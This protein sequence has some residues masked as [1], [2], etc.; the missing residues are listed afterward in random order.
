MAI[1]NNPGTGWAILP[2]AGKDH[3]ATFAVK[4][5]LG[6]AGGSTLSF[7]LDQNHG[8]GHAIGRFR[9]AVATDALPAPAGGDVPAPIQALL[10]IAVAE[11]TAE[12]RQALAAHYRSIAPALE[13][14]RQKLAATKKSRDDQNNQIPTSLITVAVAPRP[15]RVLPRG[16][17]MDDSGEEVLPGVPATLPQ[18]PAKEGRLT[19]LDLAQ[20]LMAR[21]NPL[22]SRVLANRLWKLYF[23]AGL[24]GKLDDLGV[25]GSMAHASRASRLAVCR[26]VGGRLGRETHDQ[27]DRDVQDVSA[28]VVGQRRRQRQGPVQ[29]LAGPAI[30]VSPGCRDRPRRGAMD[31][32]SAGRADRRPERQTV[33]AA[34]LLGS[35]STFPN[36]NGRTA[37]ATT[38][39]AVGCIR[40]GSGN[41]C[42]PACWPSM[43]PAARNARPIGRA[44]IRRCSRW[45]CSTT[46]PTSKRPA[47]WPS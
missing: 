38:C 34:A 2:A 30:A 4:E 5:P 9:L 18:P 17:W 11:R 23:G 41:I 13:P 27:N 10:A 42:I 3:V 1:D 32:R 43:R 40:T 39:I 7:T 31:Q 21:D 45:C 35:I 20:W 33:P 47:C 15:I 29:S 8:T 25:A 12:Q 44:R 22:P 6:A 19:R 14:A 26:P 16:N 28:V 36:E 24:S 37:S 46:L